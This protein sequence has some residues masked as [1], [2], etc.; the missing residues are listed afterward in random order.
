MN[1]H[2]LSATPIG[3][4]SYQLCEIWHVTAPDAGIVQVWSCNLVECFQKH[5]YYC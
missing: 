5:L 1:P 3:F 4:I 2:M